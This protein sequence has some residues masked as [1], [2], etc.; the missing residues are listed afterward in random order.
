MT[1]KMAREKTEI[2]TNFATL[3]SFKQF[4]NKTSFLQDCEEFNTNL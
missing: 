3:N 2:K 4:C 1:L